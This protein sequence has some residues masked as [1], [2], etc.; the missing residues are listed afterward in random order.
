[1]TVL[2]IGRDSAVW[3]TDEIEF[4]CWKLYLYIILVFLYLIILP[5]LPMVVSIVSFS[6]PVLRDDTVTQPE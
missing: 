1:M 2:E 6:H 5:R 4:G 3:A